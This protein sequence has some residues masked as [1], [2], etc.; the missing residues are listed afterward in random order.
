MRGTGR[1]G[2]ALVVLWACVCTHPARVEAVESQKR[3]LVLHPVRRDAPVSISMDGVYRQ[4]L[5]EALGPQLD[6]YSEYLDEYRFS[7]PQYQ[8]ALREYLRS[9]YAGF[10]FDAIIAIASALKFVRAPH[11][12][13]FPG[14]P[15]I[16]ASG[17]GTARSPWSTG[18]IY[19][20]DTAGTVR[21]A[22]ALQPAT[23]TIALV[24][25]T[26]AVDRGIQQT[27]RE[28]LRPFEETVAFRYLF[29]LPMADLERAIAQLPGDSIIFYLSISE[30]GA[31]QRLVPVEALDRLARH[32]PV[33]IYS[34][35][36]LL[37]GRGIVGG[38]L[39]SG[40]TVARATAALALRVLAGETPD[41]IPVEEI[42]A[43]LT[44][45][46]WRQLR[47]WH[48]DDALLPTG[49][50][51][52]FRE[53][54]VWERYRRYLVGIALLIALQSLMIG[55]LLLQRVRRREAERH[56]QGNAKALSRT[57]ERLR[58]VAG[59]L[60]SA[61]E[62]ERTRIARD[63]HDDACQEVAGAAVDVYRL[64]QRA[65]DAP[66]DPH[67]GALSNVHAR[68]VRVA[69]SLR[70]L[71]HDLH[72]S[73]LQH[74]G[75][76]GALQTHCGEVERQFDMQ[77]ALDAH[78]D[79]EP[80]DAGTALTLFRI[81]QEALGNAAR[82]GQARRVTLTVQREG[83][84]LVLAVVDDGVGFD[85]TV[86]HPQGLGLVS[87]RERVRLAHGTLAIRSAPHQ[88]TRVEVRVPAGDRS[89][90]GRDADTATTGVETTD[91]RHGR[92]EVTT[93]A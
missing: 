21:L 43:N 53:P 18:V 83:K 33:P 49:T 64:L 38:R 40:T 46:D 7:D 12:E 2:L 47:R 22:L 15:I 13:L 86:S 87:I 28:Q 69:E 68:L 78:E 90:R 59:R 66:D 32:A 75:L 3:I 19:G 30:D 92:G 88:G 51:V 55:A 72:P 48:L 25:G 11:N 27:A 6:Y 67:V 91:D 62:A 60:I 77:V 50:D 57:N 82:H 37:I 34:L 65:P 36:E 5:A 85:T 14:T 39:L 8:S 76:L 56:A 58:D 61:Q 42:D 9:R 31:G 71:S 74:V 70:Q 81:A 24:S 73:V 84:E 1:L 80:E 54:T 16:Y 29:G 45:V 26:S 4:V 63:L 79:A 20:L 44:Q 35:H 23:R 89:L 52:L 10:R 41:S 17:R 93:H